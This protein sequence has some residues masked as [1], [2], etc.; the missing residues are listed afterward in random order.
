MIHIDKIDGYQIFS[1]NPQAKDISDAIYEILVNKNT[2]IKVKLNSVEQD[3]IEETS[4]EKQCAK[5]FEENF[6]TLATEAP[7]VLPTKEPEKSKD[8]VETM[9]HW[10][11]KTNKLSSM[12]GLVLHSFSVLRH[13]EHFG[14]TSEAIKDSLKIEELSEAS[15]IFVYNPQ[16]NVVLLIRNAESQDLANDIRLGLDDLKMFML[17]FND[18]LKESNLKLISLVVTD[19]AHGFELK[20]SNCMNNVLSLEEF[21]DLATFENWV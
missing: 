8:I 5:Y 7:L 16:K 20:C 12:K 3:N 10:C 11:R 13:L 19:Q 1:H 14:F 9:E 2:N 15:I 4:F 6:E 21:K 18:K 17:L